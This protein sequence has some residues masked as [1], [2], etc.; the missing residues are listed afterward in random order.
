MPLSLLRIAVR[1]DKMSLLALSPYTA[2]VIGY[3]IPWT[4]QL[5]RHNL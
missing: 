1:D 5:W 3:D 2:W 4:Y